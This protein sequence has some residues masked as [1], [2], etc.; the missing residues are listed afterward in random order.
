M[1]EVQVQ[2]EGRAS[3]SMGLYLRA[4]GSLLWGSTQAGEMITCA[5]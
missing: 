4:M 5:V 2:V 1:A 3:K